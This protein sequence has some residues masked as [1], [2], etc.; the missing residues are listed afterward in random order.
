M[1]CPYDLD[2]LTKRARARLIARGIEPTSLAVY[3]MVGTLRSE[4]LKY[5]RTVADARVQVYP[6][7]VDVAGGCVEIPIHH[8]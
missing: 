6:E 8:T 4:D 2:A 5:R 7:T 3:H 1:D